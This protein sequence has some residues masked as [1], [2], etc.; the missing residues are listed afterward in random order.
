MVNFYQL[1]QAAMRIEK[2]EMMSRKRNL[3]RKSSRG[4]SF[5]GKRT[6]ESQVDSVH[7]SAT[8]GMITTQTVLF[9]TLI[10]TGFEHFLRSNQLN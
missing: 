10:T 5:S 2:S 7:S 4:G 9:Y 8:R 1:V 6:K 3:E